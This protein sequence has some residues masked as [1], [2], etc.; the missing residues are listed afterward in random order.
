MWF[1]LVSMTLLRRAAF[2]R[3][4]QS[5]C[6]RVCDAERTAACMN[7]AIKARMTSTHF[8]RW[9]LRDPTLGI[10]LIVS[11]VGAWDAPIWRELCVA[12]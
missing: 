4:Q 2:L 9:D 7:R 11:G 3:Q 6:E 1:W 5:R 10:E 8:L 12:E